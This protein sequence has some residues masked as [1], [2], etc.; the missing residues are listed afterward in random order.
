MDYR[1]LKRVQRGRRVVLALYRRLSNGTYVVRSHQRIIHRTHD[2]QEAR[3]IYELEK[4]K[5]NDPAQ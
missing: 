2:L 4:G 1:T 3:F 5:L